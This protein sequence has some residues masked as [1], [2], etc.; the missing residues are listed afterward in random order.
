MASQTV[1]ISLFGF[2]SPSDEDGYV[3]FSTAYKYTDELSLVAG[4][5]IFAGLDQHTMFGQFD[6]NDNLYVKA[7]YGF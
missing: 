5:N 1:T 2:Y 7:N 3:R 6:H 4:G